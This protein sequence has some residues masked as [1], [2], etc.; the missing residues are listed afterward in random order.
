MIPILALPVDTYGF[1]SASFALAGVA[2]RGTTLK[3]AHVAERKVVPGRI[4]RIEPGE[5]LGDVFGGTERQIAARGEAQVSSELMDVDVDRDKQPSRVDLPEAQIDPI[6]RPYHPPEKK[7]KALAPG[8]PARVGQKMRRAAPRPAR[9]QAAGSADR[10]APRPEGLPHRLMHGNVAGFPVMRELARKPSSERP[11]GTL[12]GARSREQ[13]GNVLAAK[14]TVLPTAQARRERLAIARKPRGVGAQTIQKILE[15]G[16]NRLHV[17]ECDARGHQGH[18]LAILDRGKTVNETHRIRRTTR[19]YIATHTDR[20]ERDLDGH[21][22]PAEG[23]G[24]G[25][26][27]GRATGSDR[28]RV[29]AA[30]RARCA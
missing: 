26:L 10:V 17:A 25:A 9:G 11:V 28:A 15:L 29:S 19:G 1:D 5:G 30:R 24:Q 27:G 2:T 14:N 3:H 21:L 22:A 12:Y 8:A 23:S 4:A 20:V 13:A 6:G 18:E 7:K 16:P